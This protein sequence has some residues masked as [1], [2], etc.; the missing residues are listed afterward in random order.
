VDCFGALDCSQG[1]LQQ[2]LKNF[3]EAHL[4]WGAELPEGIS[5]GGGLAFV[6]PMW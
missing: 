3:L 1:K 6:S 4:G 5:L 2:R